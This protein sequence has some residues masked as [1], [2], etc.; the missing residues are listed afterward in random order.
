MEIVF[1]FNPA[2]LWLSA[3]IKA[4]RE[5]CCDDMVLA[6]SS[7]VNYLKALV[8]C[9][10]YKQPSPAYAMALKGSNGGLKNRVARIISNKN[11]S[12][13]SREK[14]VTCGLPD[15]NGDIYCGVHKRKKFEPP[16]NSFAKIHTG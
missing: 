9:E 11:L 7:K 6:R 2:V 3:L 5:N 13:N 14:I 4:E 8:A 10:E 12:L 16:G 15:S 1:F